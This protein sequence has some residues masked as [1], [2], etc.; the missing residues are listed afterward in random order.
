ML[1]TDKSATPPV[2]YEDGELPPPPFE[3]PDPF[4][5]DAATAEALVNLVNEE[6]AAAEGVPPPVLHLQPPGGA[7]AA[8]AQQGSDTPRT[9]PEYRSNTPLMHP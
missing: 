6:E 2:V 3:V 5:R 8:R 1:V 7:G 9:P 4:A